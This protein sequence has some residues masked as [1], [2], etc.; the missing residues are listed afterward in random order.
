[1]GPGVVSC[2]AIIAINLRPGSPSRRESPWLSKN[3]LFQDA[4][5]WPLSHLLS[6]I[7]DVTIQLEWVRHGRSAVEALRREIHAAKGDDPLKPVTVIVESNY[8]GVATRRL[9]GS[10]G[11]RNLGADQ[12]A[13]TNA[14]AAVNFVTSRDLV[15]KLRASKGFLADRRRVSPPAAREAIRLELAERQ[16]SS[17]KAHD[18]ATLEALV[19]I[20]KELG[21]V[22]PQAI[23]G[24]ALLEPGVSTE[25]LAICR[26]ASNR[27][28][29]R[30][31]EDAELFGAAQAA[32]HEASAWLEE[33]GPIILYLPRR[34]PPPTANLLARLGDL[35][36]LKVLAGMTGSAEAD[37]PLL[38][39]LQR[40]GPEI[41]AP[42]A[43][44]APWAVVD[45][46]STQ[47]VVVSDADEEVRA[48]LRRVME[49]REAGVSLDR[50]AI[51][52]G[53]QTPYADILREQLSAA[54]IPTAGRTG[55]SITAT[56]AGR[57]VL[58][59]LDLPLSNFSR[60]EVLDWLHGA[61]LHYNN[62]PI[63]VKAWQQI[64]QEAGIV[65]GKAQWEQRLEQYVQAC[66]P[67]P[68]H[69]TPN[70]QIPPKQI[71]KFLTARHLQR[72]MRAL[73][74]DFPAADQKRT[75]AE[76]SCRTRER[77]KDLLGDPRE[78]N[79]SAHDESAAES[80]E[81]LLHRL[82]SLGNENTLI[83]LD[84]FASAV[85]SEFRANSTK[86]GR[87][88]TGLMVG[89]INMG[90]G[91]NMDEVIIVGMN[92]GSYPRK[93]VASP[94]LS[95]KL[96]DQLG[97]ERKSDDLSRQ[98]HDLL[99]VLAEADAITMCTARGNLRSTGELSPSRWLSDIEAFL[100]TATDPNTPSTNNARPWRHE[101]P[102]YKTGLTTLLSNNKSLTMPATEQ[103]YRLAY[104]LK[105]SS[106]MG[107][108]ATTMPDD[109]IITTGHTVLKERRGDRVTP[110]DGLI[111]V[112]QD[113]HIGK[114]SRN[115]RAAPESPTSLEKWAT[116]PHS[117][118]MRHVLGIRE[119]EKPEDVLGVSPLHK[120]SMVHKILEKVITKYLPSHKNPCVYGSDWTDADAEFL[121]STCSQ[122]FEEYEAEVLEINPLL[123]A[124]AKQQIQKQVTDF[125]K[126]DKQF[127]KSSN[128]APLAVEYEFTTELKAGS[129]PDSKSQ[130]I[131][132]GKIDR[133]DRNDEN[134]LLI[135]D[136][137][138]GRPDGYS[139][140]MK[141]GMWSLGGTKLQLGLYGIAVKNNYQS[142]KITRPNRI[143][144]EYRF[145]DPSYTRKPIRYELTEEV[146]NH[147]YNVAKKILE[148]I[149]SGVFI[150]YPDGGRIECP[151]CSPDGMS[152]MRLR[153]QI[154][155]KL[156][157]LD[158]KSISTF[159]DVLAART[160]KRTR[161]DLEA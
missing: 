42:P 123:W 68:P 54:Q 14:Y 88:G 155:R 77:V 140:L 6:T 124:L 29:Q 57:T 20:H 117:Y 113:S 2:H 154:E 79:G 91:L 134:D 19:A 104:L 143:F 159:R 23:T 93:N 16:T 74:D 50:I 53:S 24:L 49:A 26:G 65:Q 62:Q 63:N 125:L 116:C 151:Y 139:Q 153:K 102:S 58:K 137:K 157:N 111:K 101:V 141:D 148:G 18:D 56:M 135:I 55:V 64:C 70:Q 145:V 4:G 119:G 156:D 13:T 69:E 73:I 35:T 36:E 60:A 106:G 103:D 27:L 158:N 17:L 59:M 108:G 120:G 115:D 71:E 129:Q 5:A 38:R 87:F 61:P 52:Y 132:Q 100:E 82:G 39:P 127:S 96:R 121:Q 144:V 138:T 67:P 80:I 32:L 72:F 9:L 160:Q 83:G 147:H 128:Y 15:E 89:P 95:D 33:L 47:I 105:T 46:A 149:T 22:S 146:S 118:F 84:V 94:L 92:E 161:N 41:Q 28:S 136:Y 130:L 66:Q 126:A 75:W 97:L 90:V 76:H 12:D 150:P 122:V 51:L 11:S 43:A 109:P 112:G 114:R 99:A 31:Y 131:Y 98:Q 7:R 133:V 10:A 37:A 45:P 85:R 107:T 25:V 142:L 30:Y 48:A 110:F 86:A 21:A 152:A 81:K 8:Q 40:I 1:M 34:L 44:Q 3:W 78:W